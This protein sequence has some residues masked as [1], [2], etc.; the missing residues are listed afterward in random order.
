MNGVHCVLEIGEL[1]EK[2]IIITPGSLWRHKAKGSVYIVVT[3]SRME[4]TLEYAITYRKV[5]EDYT[6]ETWTRPA[7]EFVEKFEQMLFHSTR[8]AKC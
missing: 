7:K 3:G 6:D 8:T 1:S 2:R 4:S 5:G